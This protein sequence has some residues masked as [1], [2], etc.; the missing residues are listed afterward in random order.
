MPSLVL[1]AGRL[2]VATA[3]LGPIALLRHG[4]AFKALGARD[5]Q[6]LMLSGLLLGLHFSTW[7]SALEYTSVLATVVLGSTSPIFVLVF[8]IPFLKERVSRVVI[9]GVAITF[10]GGILVAL[11][12]ESGLAPTRQAPMLGNL[13]ALV[14]AIAFALYLIIGR[15]IRRK[16]HVIP[17]ITAVYGSAAILVALACLWSGES[18]TGHSTEGYLWLLAVGLIP[19]LLGH[20]SFN[21]ALGHLPVAYVGLV[22]RLEPVGST[23]L[24]GFVLWEW[25]GLL[26]L[27]GSVIIIIGVA[28]PS[29]KMGNED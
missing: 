6:L 1:A 25:P 5:W 24:A 4:R 27:G 9:L 13:L 20:S 7:I 23:L 26:A 15:R 16:L 11:G 28:I 17:Y 19:Q 12:G 2:A 18:I 8:S 10:V 14:A 3:V 22:T 29:W 21:Y